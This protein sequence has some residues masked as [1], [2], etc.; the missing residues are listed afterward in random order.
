MVIFAIALR[1][2]L[3][4]PEDNRMP[5][6]GP[7]DHSGRTVL[8]LTLALCNYDFFSDLLYF[9]VKVAD[10][11]HQ[12]ASLTVVSIAT[13]VAPAIAC[14][15]R[16]DFFG[17]FVRAGSKIKEDLKKH[18]LGGQRIE[19]SLPNTIKFAV[20]LSLGLLSWT[21]VLLGTLVLGVNLKLFALGRFLRFYRNFL[22]WN[23]AQD[24]EEEKAQVVALNEA[25]FFEL[26]LESVPQ[27][28]VV[29]INESLTPGQWSSI[30]IITLAG[31]IFSV[32]NLLWKFAA[33][34]HKEKSFAE[35]LRVPVIACS[36]AQRKDI[37]DFEK[38]PVKRVSFLSR[39]ASSLRRTASATTHDARAQTQ[40]MDDTR[41]AQLQL[42]RA[43][44]VVAAQAQ[45]QAH[46]ITPGETPP[47]AYA[48]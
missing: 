32:L 29:I 4:G 35:A 23:G 45:A 37:Q 16:N 7:F 17:E 46:P 19:S 11:G 18:I 34:V 2:Q 1:G 31:S 24:K 9:T 38:V 21:F 47:T 36:K 27:I 43:G 39:T 10:G 6:G 26:T 8:F 40:P 30:A 20:L 25:L 3:H 14:A 48:L 44:A 33:R 12:H 22:L 41:H 28:C 5:W 13:F 42:A 15:L